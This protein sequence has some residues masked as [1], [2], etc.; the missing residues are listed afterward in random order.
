MAWIYDATKQRHLG[1]GL[2]ATLD[3]LLLYVFGQPSNLS[4][5]IWSGYCTR[6][7]SE[8]TA[9][10]RVTRL[11]FE[12]IGKNLSEALKIRRNS[13]CCKAESLAPQH[14]K[15]LLPQQTFY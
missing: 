13:G 3:L 14:R 10:S 5:T 11:I 1:I 8:A 2:L 12:F 4:N 9:Q 6:S 15:L 7:N